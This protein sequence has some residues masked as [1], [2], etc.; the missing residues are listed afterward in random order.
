MAFSDFPGDIELGMVAEVSPD[1]GKVVQYWNSQSFQIL[2]RT[3]PGEHQYL[4]RRY[5]TRAQDYLISL[6]REGLAA[7]VDHHPSGP[8][9]LY[10]DSLNGAVGPDGQIQPVT[11]LT[12][13][14]QRRTEPDPVVVVGDGRSNA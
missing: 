10:Q 2:R 5:R 13:I 6:R 4:G 14:T 11:T 12:E 7:A 8:P 9:V 1:A 3:Y